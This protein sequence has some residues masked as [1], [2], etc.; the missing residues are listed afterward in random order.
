RVLGVRIE[1]TPDELAASTVNTT[2]STAPAEPNSSARMTNT[3]SPEH[4]SALDSASSSESALPTADSQPL[5]ADFTP[6]RFAHLATAMGLRP[7]R[8]PAPPKGSDPVWIPIQEDE[9]PEITRNIHGDN[10]VGTYEQRYKLRR[11]KLDSHFRQNPNPTPREIAHAITEIENVEKIQAEEHAQA[12]RL[13][14]TAR[15]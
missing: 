1:S 7:L 15:Q 14:E 6:S 4:T 5:T 11:I 10:E 13:M 9:F 2:N 12:M 8:T 3:E